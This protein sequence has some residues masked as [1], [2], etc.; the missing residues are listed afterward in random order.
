MKTNP[1]KP[2]TDPADVVTRDDIAVKLERAQSLAEVLADAAGGGGDIASDNV[3]NVG[4]II[5]SEIAQAHEL[6]EHYKGQAK[7]PRNKAA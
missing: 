7:P 1:R 6:L 4:L 2:S 5:A 3:Y